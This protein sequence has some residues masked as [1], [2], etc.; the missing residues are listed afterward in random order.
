MDRPPVTLDYATP[1]PAAGR[2]FTSVVLTVELLVGVIAITAFGA[3][4]FPHFVAVW[5]QFGTSLPPITAMMIR[6]SRWLQ[7]PVW[8]AGLLWMIPVFIPIAATRWAY[9]ADSAA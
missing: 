1:P 8:W 5:A 9:R 3:F 2:P 4:Q 7:H 6:F